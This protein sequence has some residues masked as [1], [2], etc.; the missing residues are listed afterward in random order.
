MKQESQRRERSARAGEV[1]GVLDRGAEA[2]RA[3]HGAVAAGQAALR[4]VVPARV[5]EIAEE[6]R[7]DVVGAHVPAHIG[8]GVRDDASSAAST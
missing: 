4:D 6:E 3:D 8:G 1:A 7:V 2:G 5:L